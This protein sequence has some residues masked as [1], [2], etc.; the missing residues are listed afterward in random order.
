M[1]AGAEVP[2][3]QRRGT[4]NKRIRT[5]RAGYWAKTDVEHAQDGHRGDAAWQQQSRRPAW[6]RSKW[7]EE[8]EHT[9]SEIE[10]SDEGR[11]GEE[12]GARSREAVAACSKR[13]EARSQRRLL[14]YTQQM[15]PCAVEARLEALRA[16][17]EARSK[18][19]EAGTASRWWGG[20]EGWP[21]VGCAE[22]GELQLLEL[23][24]EEGELTASV[25][26]CDQKKVHLRYMERK[27]DAL[28]YQDFF[29]LKKVY[30]RYMQRTFRNCEVGDAVLRPV[31]GATQIAWLRQL[32][33]DTG[34]PDKGKGNEEA[35]Q[36]ALRYCSALQCHSA[37]VH[38]HDLGFAT[39]LRFAFAAALN[40]VLDDPARWVGGWHSHHVVK[41]CIRVSPHGAGEQLCDHFLDVMG[42]RSGAGQRPERMRALAQLMVETKPGEFI[43]RVLIATIQHAP[44]D[45]GPAP[46][47]RNAAAD[48][49][50]TQLRSCVELYEGCERALTLAHV[51][52]K[53]FIAPGWRRIMEVW[54]TDEGA[55][56]LL[57]SCHAVAVLLECLEEPSQAGGAEDAQLFRSLQ[58][59]ILSRFER[60]LTT[61]PVEQEW[62]SA[63][64]YT[65]V[66]SDIWSR[67]PQRGRLAKVLRLGVRE[68]L[69][70][71]LPE[72]RRTPLAKRSY[73]S[74][75]A[76][77]TDGGAHGRLVL[78][79]ARPDEALRRSR[80][81]CKALEHV[82][83]A[84]LELMAQSRPP[85]PA[86]AADAEL[87][88][89]EELLL[90]ARRA[91]RR[92][93][94]PPASPCFLPLAWTEEE[95]RAPC[96]LAHSDFMDFCKGTL[97]KHGFPMVEALHVYDFL[98]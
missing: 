23:L 4:W 36:N 58:A 10:S 52:L 74:A 37:L 1:V 31:G 19:E 97:F 34:L 62:Y 53:N 50:V 85:P 25:D 30:F 66:E 92:A 79:A 39:D 89:R 18:R 46:T 26:S 20:G 17:L 67:K 16:A 2:A 38:G 6:K 84:L 75:P 28:S 22:R 29:D 87:L 44:A 51:M 90:S 73:R 71:E 59:T 86:V 48:L 93:P 56:Q 14:G 78:P 61:Q 47:L 42:E 5:A 88:L 64:G 76:A 83:H 82:G 60:L 8:P 70:K 27:V 3:E 49:A 7:E 33:L 65:A 15:K 80:R 69:G 13:R 96:G 35:R 41:A 68:R 98:A 21:A 54:A 72:L 9:P 32:S 43:E 81:P 40:T 57:R 45:A 12:Q 55:G 24:Q 63:L 11:K 94:C 91:L 95:P 77:G